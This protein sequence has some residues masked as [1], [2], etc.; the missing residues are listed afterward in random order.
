[1]SLQI[2]KRGQGYYTRLWSGLSAFALAAWGSY[3]LYETLATTNIWVQTLVPFGVCAALGLF[4]F[5]LVNKPNVADFMIT[6]EGEVKKVSW[7]SRK[8]IYGSTV[9][10]ICVVIIMSVLMFVSDIVFSKAINAII[11]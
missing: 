1:M 4:L 5:W 10:V 3:R 8:E 7:A 2:Y 9:V 11:L 6:S